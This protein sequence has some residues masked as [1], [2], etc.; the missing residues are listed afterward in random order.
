MIQILLEPEVAK[1]LGTAAFFGI[2]F[3][4]LYLISE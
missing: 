4:I 1:F 3:G 2:V